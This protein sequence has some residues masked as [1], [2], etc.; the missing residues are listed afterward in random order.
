MAKVTPIR[1]K[2][3]SDGHRLV[4]GVDRPGK[5]PLQE[6]YCD[7]RIGLSWPSAHNPG[8]FCVAGLQEDKTPTGERRIEILDESERKD[9]TPLFQRLATVCM[10]YKA[11]WVLANMKGHEREY[12][13]LG[14]F[15]KKNNVKH[16]SIL[17]TAEFADMEETLPTISDLV[18]ARRMVKMS[19]RLKLFGQLET[20]QNTELKPIGKVQPEERFHAYYAFSHIV[21][22]YQLYPFRKPRSHEAPKRRSGYGG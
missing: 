13:A 21:T 22:S 17:D 12:E 1:P 15:I 8:Y 14:L 2:I 10:T 7:R 3:Y 9:L 19:P 6:I 11:K 16:I 18:I 5:T 4:I 20:V